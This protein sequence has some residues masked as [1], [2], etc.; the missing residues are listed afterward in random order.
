MVVPLTVW[1]SLA[2]KEV[3]G[4]DLLLTVCAHKVFGVPCAAHG[5]HHL[6]KW[7]SGKMIRIITYLYYR[8]IIL[9]EASHLSHNWLTA[10]AA[11]SFSDRLHAQFVE[12]RL[13]ATKHVV[14]LVDLCRRP[15]GN[16]ALPLGHNL[17]WLNYVL[18]MC[19]I[20]K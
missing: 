3:P 16:T 13:Q 2:L 9:T 5:G 1:L 8:Y 10:G 17:K 11:N 19:L 18:K 12:V 20:T 7:K 6:Y 14:Q 15:T 4:A